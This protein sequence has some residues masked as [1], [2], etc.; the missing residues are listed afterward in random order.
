MGVGVE[1]RATPVEFVWDF[2]D[3]FSTTGAVLRTT[4]PGAR[5]QQGMGLPG[6]G[7]VTH[8]FDRLG[9][10]DSPAGRAAGVRRHPVN[11]L[12]FRPVDISVRTVWSGQFRL[13]GYTGWIGIAGQVTTVSEVGSFTLTEAKSALVCEDLNGNTVC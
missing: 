12:R 2:D 10:P 7:W 8:T 11:H 5:W 9:D 1:I 3:P 4:D 13:V 6:P